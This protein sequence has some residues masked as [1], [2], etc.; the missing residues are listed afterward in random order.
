MR[1]SPMRIGRGML[2]ERICKG[3][4]FLDGGFGEVGI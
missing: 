2:L 4:F 1:G 3:G